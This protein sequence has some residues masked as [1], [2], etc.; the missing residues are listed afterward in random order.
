LRA[1]GGKASPAGR[2]TEDRHVHADGVAPEYRFA[3]VG[4]GWRALFYL[5][6]AA[7]LPVRFAVSGVVTRTRERAESVRRQWGV[8]AYPSLHDLMEGGAT[9]LRRALGA[10]FHDARLAGR[11]DSRGRARHVRDGA[12]RRPGGPPAPMQAVGE[13]ATT[14]LLNHLQPGGARSATADTDLLPVTLVNRDSVIA[15]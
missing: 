11:V 12:R 14:L 10:P 9:R 1:G 8:A 2:M 6:V 5:R 13:L 4:A 3:I 15:R 7:A